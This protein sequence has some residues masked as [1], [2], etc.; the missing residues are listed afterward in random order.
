MSNR[1]SRSAQ[2]LQSEDGYVALFAALVLLML[3]SIIGISASRVANTEISMARN[4]VIYHRNFFLAE[5]AA[6]EAADRLANTADLKT[7][8]PVWME[9]AAGALDYTN[10]RTYFSHATDPSATVIPQ[11]SELD[12]NR[13]LYV[14]G[15]DGTAPGEGLDPDRPKI[16]AI[17][18]YGRCEWDGVSIIKIGYRAAY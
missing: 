11:A 17:S 5:G 8:M 12:L 3:L 18:V 7:Q 1:R 14:G 13:T 2:R 9:T 15:V 6:M 10:L 16:Y 4:E